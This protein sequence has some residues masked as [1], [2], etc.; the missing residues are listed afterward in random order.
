MTVLATYRDPYPIDD[1][2]R[3]GATLDAPDVDLGRRCPVC[4]ITVEA[5]TVIVEAAS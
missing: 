1:C 4:G 3:C 5:A 2:P